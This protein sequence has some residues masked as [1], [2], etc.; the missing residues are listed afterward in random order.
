MGL[1]RL[2]ERLAWGGGGL[3]DFERFVAATPPMRRVLILLAGGLL[4]G[5]VALAFAVLGA[6]ASPF[7]QLSGNGRDLAEPLFT[8]SYG[9][10]VVAALLV[11]KPLATAACLGSGAPC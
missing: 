2:A 8:G 3:G 6:L 11:L 9:L 5:G 7:P 10:P 1:L 4:V